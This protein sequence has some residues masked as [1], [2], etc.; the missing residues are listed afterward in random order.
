MIMMVTGSHGLVGSAL[1]PALEGAGHTVRRLSLRGQPVNP[2]VLEQVDAIVHLAGE[3]IA[4]GRWT[5]LQK[6]TIRDSRVEGTRALCQALGRLT[7]PPKALICAS[8]IGYYGDRG[9]EV[10]REDSRP[11]VGFL[12]DVGVA[13]EQAAEPARRQGIRVVHL[14]FGII[15]ARQGPASFAW[16][17]NPRGAGPASFGR[18]NNPRGAG[19]ALAKMVTPFRLGVGGPLGSGRQWFSW[20]SLDDVVGVIQFALATESLRGPVNVVAPRPVTNAEFTQ[21]LGRVLR[22]P[23]VLPVPAFALRLLLGEMADGLLLASTRVEPAALAAAGYRFRHPEL[24]PALK[25]LLA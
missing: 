10:L 5:P 18:R 21:V 15:L 7:T 2:A 14:R 20:I 23:A 12:P 25:M 17:N 22:R 3:P 19:G 11:G 16:R 4:A 8:A 13:W 24:E 1:V 9:E 6:S